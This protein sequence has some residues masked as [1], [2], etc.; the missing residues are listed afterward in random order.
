MKDPSQGKVQGKVFIKLE[1]L[2]NRSSSAGRQCSNFSTLGFRK[3]S[4]HEFK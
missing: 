4:V 3:I 2:H 1:R